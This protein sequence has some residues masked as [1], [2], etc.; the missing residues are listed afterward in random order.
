MARNVRGFAVKLYTQQ[1]NWDIVG[2][3]IPVFLIQDAVKFPDLIHA[4][5]AE[6]DR[7]F[8][9]AQTAHDNFWDFI[10]LIPESMHM[11]MWAM[12]DLAIPRSLRFMEAFVV[13]TFRLADRN[14]KATFFKFHWKPKLGMQSVLWN[15]AVKLNGAVA[16]PFWVF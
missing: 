15:E 9:Q 4:A 6:P 5:K 10:S 12:S 7:D 14:G 3:N 8:P 11:I 16:H 1:G 13:H 2:N